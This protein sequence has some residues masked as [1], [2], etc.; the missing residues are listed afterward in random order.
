[1]MAAFFALL[2]FILLPTKMLASEPAVVLNE[3]YPPTTSDWVELY[4][5]SS[6]EVDI[7]GWKLLDTAVTP[8]K[9]IPENKKVSSG[10][11]LVIE[12]SNRLNKG[13]DTIRL[14]NKDGVEIDS[15]K[16]DASSE[17]NSFARIPDGSGSW[18]GDQN[19]TKEASNG[20][21]PP[22]EESISGKRTGKIILTEFMP[23]PDE[24]KEWAEVY[25]PGSF[26]IDISLW[27]IDDIEG[28][29]SPYTIPKGTKISA[30][31]YKIFT[32]SSKLNNSG[33]SIRLLNP[34]G[35]IIETYS[36][37]KTAKGVAF[38]KDSGGKWKATTTPTP[39]KPNKITGDIALASSQNLGTAQSSSNF[40]STGLGPTIDYLSD[41]FQIEIPESTQEVPTQGQVAGVRERGNQPKS[42]VTLL[43]ATGVAFLGS[44]LAWPFL[45]KRKII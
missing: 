4:N 16:Y 10:S 28:A 27:K 43:I 25:N 3:I 9:V 26:E 37:K 18:F 8:M 21:D 38:A 34:D 19:P 15:F 23:N 36:F 29:S 39:G 44:A 17:S 2:V 14:V 42:L 41:T 5:N 31:S 45:E 12:V 11:F 6:D 7:S 20:S 35:K 1:M 32:F 33:D 40:G 22:K 24:G 13:G 30:Q